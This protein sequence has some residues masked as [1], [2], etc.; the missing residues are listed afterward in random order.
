MTVENALS[1][2]PGAVLAFGIA[3][4]ALLFNQAIPTVSAV[5]VAILL[6]VLLGNAWSLPDTMQPG[7]QWTTKRLLRAAIVLLGIRLSFI[8]VLRIG[9]LSALV[10]V[11]CVS[12]ALIAANALGRR[13]GLPLPLRRLLGVGTAICGVSAVMAC[14]PLFEA[15]ED[16]VVYAVSTITLLGVLSVLAY[17]IVGQLLA[18]NDAAFGMWAGLAIHDTSQVVAAGFIFSDGAGAAA[19][20]VK[21][22]RTMMLVPVM[23]FFSFLRAKKTDYGRAFPWFVVGF[24]L[25]AALRTWGD[26]WLAS[27]GWSAVVRGISQTA[28]LMIPMA[29][30][31][32]GTSIQL[33]KLTKQGG[34]ALVVGLGTSAL[35]SLVSLGFALLWYG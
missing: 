12:L 21:L 26:V 6:G 28:N 5:T 23:V 19:T 16:D 10:I 3:L 20:V 1:L 4:A 14:V 33:K 29:V 24:L 27:P 7:L 15:D 8:D 34:P 11:L 17:P 25:M 35:V 9:G 30:A 13:L 32:L 18:L 2:L 31:A 22:T